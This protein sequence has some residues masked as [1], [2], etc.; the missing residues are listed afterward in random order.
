MVALNSGN[1]KYDFIFTTLDNVDVEIYVDETD[2]FDLEATVT[3]VNK[4]E[5]VTISK[6]EEVYVVVLPKNNSAFI[7][8]SAQYFK[9]S[10][11]ILSAGA[12]VGIVLGVTFVLVLSVIACIY[13]RYK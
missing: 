13:V 4:K 12:I 7:Q 3:E 5:D 10:G 6:Q 2:E 1:A 9:V 11:K 8:F